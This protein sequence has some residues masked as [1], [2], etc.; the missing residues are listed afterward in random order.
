[1][2]NNAPAVL[3]FVALRRCAADLQRSADFYRDGLGFEIV[4]QTPD[5]IV[6]SLGAQRIV[7][8]EVGS[9]VTTQRVS[10]PDLRFQHVAIA[11]NDMQA[12]VARLQSLM[13]VVISRDGPQRLPAASGGVCAFKFRDPDGHPLELIEFPP[14]QGAPCWRNPMHGAAGPCMGIDHAAIS[15]SDVERSIAFYERLGFI[16]QSRQL[17]RGPEQARLDGLGDAEVEVVALMP[18]QQSTPHLELLGYR[19]PAPLRGDGA[20]HTAADQL[21]WQTRARHDGPGAAADRPAMTL[22]D[23][24]GHLHR[25][26]TASI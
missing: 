5:E 20:T 6:L 12:A 23:P 9:E 17:N 4:D 19:V 22:A 24:D 25:F 26:V 7:L 13:P 8:T 16:V 1:M 21:V 18:S 14:G 15:V 11:V 3:G 10:G 2:M